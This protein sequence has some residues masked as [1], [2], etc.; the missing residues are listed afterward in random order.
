MNF[1]LAVGGLALWAY[2]MWWM[3]QGSRAQA[4]GRAM[5]LTI[6]VLILYALGFQF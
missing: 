1:I 6:I 3:L 2:L 5:F 4:R